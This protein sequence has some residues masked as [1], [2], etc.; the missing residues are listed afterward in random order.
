MKLPGVEIGEY[1]SPGT[2]KYGD[3]RMESVSTVE[4]VEELL[5]GYP[6]NANLGG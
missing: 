1:R 5:D 2:S 4:V 6:S 3:G